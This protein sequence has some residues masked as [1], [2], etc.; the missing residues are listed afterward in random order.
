MR[1]VIATNNEN[2]VREMKQ[3]LSPLGYGV[4]SQKEAGVSLEVEETGMTFAENA[5]LKARAL[6]ARLGADVC[7]VADDSGI[8]VDALHG[9]PGVYSARY[10]GE[11]CGAQACNE[12]L[13]TNLKEVPRAERT[14]RFVCA[15]HFIAQDGTEITTQGECEG[16]VGYEPLGDGGFGYDPVFMMGTRSMAQLSAEE[17]NV[18]SHRAKA[19]RKLYEALNQSVGGK[20]L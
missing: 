19:L 14:A 6:R 17:K 5:A 11:G 20:G 18:V 12:K 3:I 9:A 8:V 10:A 1:L 16:W 7:V 15:I 4:V 13:L 2:K